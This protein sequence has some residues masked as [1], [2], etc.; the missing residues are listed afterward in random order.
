M[1]QDD[2]VRSISKYLHTVDYIQLRAVSKKHR[3]ILSLRRSYSTWTT[4]DLSPWMVFPI[5]NRSVY[6][7]VNSMHNNDNYLMKI[8]ESL[9]GSRIRFSKGGWLLIS[10]GK[11]LF[12]YNPFTR[13]SIELPELPDEHCY[14]FSGISFSSAPTSS[15]CVVFGVSKQ[16][17]DNVFTFYI[18][19]GDEHW[20][21]VSFDGFYWLPDRKPMEFEADFNSPVFL[22]WSILLLRHQWNFRS[23]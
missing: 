19:R 3:S 17:G 2:M 22:S 21:N 11:T 12:F 13:S 1:L 6:N 5:Y 9:K 14:D 15:D 4:P 8:P 7:F 23:M 10:K 20:T 18:K 16:I